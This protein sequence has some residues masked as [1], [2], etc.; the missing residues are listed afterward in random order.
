M[1]G[2]ASKEEGSP[3]KKA[4]NKDVTFR[5]SRTSRPGPPAGHPS[6]PPYGVSARSASTGYRDRE[7]VG[8]KKRA[9][10]ARNL[11]KVFGGPVMICESGRLGLTA[12]G[13]MEDHNRLI[14]FIVD[15]SGVENIAM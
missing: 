12:L 15:E 10:T 7:A 1:L 3:R 11:T 2:R 14:H 4:Q 5:G 8:A 6:R 9:A 13:I